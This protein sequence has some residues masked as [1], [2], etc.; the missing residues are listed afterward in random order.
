M[1]S[2]LLVSLFILPVIL[3]ILAF[4]YDKGKSGQEDSQ[5]TNTSLDSLAIGC[6][7]DD[8]FGPHNPYFIGIWGGEL[9]KE[10]WFQRYCFLGWRSLSLIESL[11][12][13]YALNTE[14]PSSWE[15]LDN[16]GLYPIRPADPVTGTQFIFGQDPT[17]ERDYSHIGIGSSE[18]CWRLNY[19]KPTMPEGEWVEYTST[20]E[21]MQ[22][23]EKYQSILQ[24]YPTNAAIRG[25][26]L[27]DSLNVILMYY[28]LRR[29]SM[30]ASGEE[31]LEGLWY[32]ANSWAD[33][34]PLEEMKG[35]GAFV[36]GI[37]REYEWAIAIWRDEAGR[38]Y[39]RYYDYSPWP[40]QGWDHVP[41]MSEILEFY[42][43]TDYGDQYFGP[44]SDFNREEY[45]MPT[46]LWS[47]NLISE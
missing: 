21:P 4:N 13:Y 45:I 27:Q 10:S 25:A 24:R 41:T 18:D 1:N 33:N 14:Y 40:I 26:S 28:V 47:C 11:E 2:K 5:S 6:S 35:P 39:V 16:S 31:L 30:P 42:Q 37:D 8:V 32:S 19:W 17:Y 15:E 46:I 34:K 12:Y 43:E 3:N 23:S 7:M 44:V 9:T 22:S 38:V 36:F 20:L 29:N